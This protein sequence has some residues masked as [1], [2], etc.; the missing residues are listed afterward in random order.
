MSYLIA[1]GG[2]SYR[3]LKN[4]CNYLATRSVIFRWRHVQLKA[5]APIDQLALTTKLQRLRRFK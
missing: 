5:A 4:A 3:L 1:S 2:A